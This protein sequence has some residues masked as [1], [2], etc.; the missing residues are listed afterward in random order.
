M[1]TRVIGLVLALAASIAAEP[2]AHGAE[3]DAPAP[4]AS[5]A[6]IVVEPTAAARELLVA[7]V[8]RVNTNPTTTSKGRTRTTSPRCRRACRSTAEA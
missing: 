5:R 4:K 3:P 6:M 2:I 8:K 1:T 7:R